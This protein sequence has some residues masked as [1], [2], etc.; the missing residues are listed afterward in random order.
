MDIYQDYTAVNN[1]TLW[2]RDAPVRHVGLPSQYIG[3]KKK[4]MSGLKMIQVIYHVSMFAI[5]IYFFFTL[6]SVY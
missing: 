3:Q 6:V 5:I 2:A 4:L 1:T